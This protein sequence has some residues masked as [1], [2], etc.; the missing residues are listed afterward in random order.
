MSTNNHTPQN[1]SKK[2]SDNRS[3]MRKHHKD[4]TKF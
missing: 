3:D 2:G 4:H 1:N